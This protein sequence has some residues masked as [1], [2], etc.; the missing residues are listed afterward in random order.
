MFFIVNLLFRDKLQLLVLCISEAAVSG[1]CIYFCDGC[2]NKVTQGHKE[3]SFVLFAS[4]VWDVLYWSLGCMQ[5][6]EQPTLGPRIF[7]VEVRL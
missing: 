2:K 7:G 6:T 1:A 5:V 4:F 3:S